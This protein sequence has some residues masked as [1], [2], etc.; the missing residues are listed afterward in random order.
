MTLIRVEPD[1]GAPHLEPSLS[2]AI[3]SMV[4][5]I[6]SDNFWMTPWKGP[7]PFCENFLDVKLSCSGN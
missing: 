6:T 5:H 4:V 3:L 1:T 2:P 7:T